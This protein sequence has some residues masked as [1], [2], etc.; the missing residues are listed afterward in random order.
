M[1]R[2]EL[3]GLQDADVEALRC[4]TVAPQCVLRHQRVFAL[5]DVAVR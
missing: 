1:K 3:G 2:L 4:S 5:G